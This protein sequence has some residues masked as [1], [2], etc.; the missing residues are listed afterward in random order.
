MKKFLYTIIVLWAANSALSDNAREYYIRNSEFHNLDMITQK[1]AGKISGL[2]TGNRISID[3][4]Y[5]QGASLLSFLEK[6]GYVYASIDS[7]TYSINSNQDSVSIS[8]YLNNNNPATVS[9]IIVNGPDTQQIQKYYNPLN[10]IEIQKLK[11]ELLA[12]QIIH[13]YEEKG[14]P[15][16]SL[17]FDSVRVDKADGKYAHI[18]Y[19]TNNPGPKLVIEDINITGNEFTN[20]NVI[21]RETRIKKGKI[22]NHQKIELIESRLM[23]LGYFKKVYPPDVFISNKN[24]G[25]ISIHVNEGKTSKFDGVVG[26]TPA[27]EFEKGY[28]TG[29]VDI[30]M[31]NLFGTGRSVK[32]HWQKRDQNS[33]DLEIYYREPWVAG[34]PLHIGSGFNQLIQDSTYIER[35]FMADFEWPLIESFSIVSSLT[36]SLIIP[37]SIGSYSLGI[38]QSNSLSASIGIK[39]DSRNN[40]INPTNGIYYFT[41][42]EIGSKKNKGPAEILTRYS[43]KKEISN[44]KIRLDFDS[45]F[46]IFTRQILAISF[47]GRRITSNESE[48]P[49]PDQYRLGGTRS[50]RGYRED[51]FRGTTIAWT[52]FEY[53]YLFGPLSRAFVFFDAGYYSPNNISDNFK[54]GYGFGV[55]LETGL[56]IMG[57]D[58]GLPIAEKTEGV[59]G[60]M[61]HV[62]LINNF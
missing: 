24:K 25:G 36:R 43:Y 31:G 49:L 40:L 50:L 22:Y 1:Q 46:S 28:F 2:E 17:N 51:Q 34:Y 21:R 12:E 18:L 57:I 60:G 56:G 3:D 33:Q 30:E 19:F 47:N 48:I 6:K 38:P 61:I 55:R 8:V 59:L 16:A 15:F 62:G 7:I 13:Y 26:Y 52:N 42:I 5:L 32:I 20:D 23:R 37:D 39:Y 41:N 35:E 53:R 45:Y 9:Q 58:Y 27:T 14:R 4:I 54:M 11:I 44:K 10:N 29:L